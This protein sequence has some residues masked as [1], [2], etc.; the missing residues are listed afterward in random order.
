[1]V[2]RHGADRA[3]PGAGHAAEPAPDHAGADPVRRQPWSVLV[4]LCVAQFMVVLDM[5]VVNIALP[6]IGRTLGFD[7]ADLQW[8]VT[9]YLLTTGALT[10]AGGRAA[11]LFGRRRMFLAGLALFTGASLASGLAPTAGALI[12]A[13]AGQGL[14]AAMLTPAAL[15]IITATYSGAQRAAAL[16]AWGALAGGGMAVGVL[17]GGVLT[18]WFGWRS[19]FLINVPV[20]L[21]AGVAARLLVPRSPG[22]ERPGLTLFPLRVLRSYSLAAGGLLLLAVT[23]TLVGVSVLN[24]LYLQNAAGASPVRAGLEFLPLVLATALGAHLASRLL[25]GAGTRV[26]AVA[27]LLAIAAGTLLLSRAGVHTSYLAAILPAFVL[28]GAGT[29]L[30][31]PAASVT[32]LS[33]VREDMAGFASGLMTTAHEIG[34]GIGAAAFPALA[35]ATTGFAASG[36]GLAAGYRH[37]T[38]AA[39]VVAAGLAVLAARAVPSVRP[40]AGAKVAVH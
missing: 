17:A 28:L 27:G 35:A 22:T 8:V 29:G 31:F 30:A 13:R 12:A 32:A 9:T 10:L 34:A 40:A 25:R 14:G 6:S 15:A 4:L 26:V 21:A 18:T 37:A 33:Q 23:G 16:S 7:P 11:D 5:T 1:M 36:A 2:L 39:A 38:L 3:L 24:S 19:V 20:G